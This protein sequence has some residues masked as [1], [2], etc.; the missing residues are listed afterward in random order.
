M[1]V[2]D[3][4]AHALPS[5]VQAAFHTWLDDSGSQAEG[6]RSLWAS[7]AFTSVERHLA[8]MDDAGID[9]AVLTFSSNAITAM[10]NAAHLAPRP[11]SGPQTIRVVND[12]LRGW[13]TASGGRLQSTRW[14][15]PRLIDSAIAEI[16]RATQDGGIHAVGMHTAYQDESGTSLRFL[17]DPE[18]RP[19]LR[20]ARDLDVTVFLHASAKM[21]AVPRSGLAPAAAACL[22]G[23]LNMLIENTACLARL[24]L[25]GVFNQLPELRLVFGQ[26]GG[27]FPFVL[28][29]FDMLQQMLS[30]VGAETARAAG[31]LPRLRDYAD[32]V[33]LDT[34]SMDQAAV[35]CALDA[36][37]P[38]RIVFGSDFPV[39]PA[40]LGRASALAAL[41]A[42]ALTSEELPHVLGGTAENLLGLPAAARHV[43]LRTEGAA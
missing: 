30:P 23:G 26:L 36:V 29:R 21:D 11:L 7:P 8:S 3:C 20:A 38:R 43:A 6:P 31:G 35:Q 1:S 22:N 25:T 41:Q 37:G 14:V 17:D 27:L 39:T 40:P 5:W 42:S 34:H 10:H 24:V 32:H 19:V 2:V 9:T 18:F 28:G 13:A 12:E 15:D 16:E 4:H 33:Y